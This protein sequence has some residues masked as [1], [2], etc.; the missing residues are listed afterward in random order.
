MLPSVDILLAAYNGE[1]Y[2]SQQIQSILNQTHKPQNIFINIDQS[3][4]K[5]VMIVQKYAKEFSEIHIINLNKRFGSSAANFFY[6]L[7]HVNFLNSDYVA[8]ADQDDIWN[9]D[10]LEKA[11]NKLKEGYD[12]YSSNVEA[13]WGNGEKKVLIKNQ[14]QKNYDHLF[15]SAG[16]G[17]TFVLK[18]NLALA[19]QKFLKQSQKDLIQMKN[20]HDWLIYTFARENNFH[21]FIDDYVSLKY[22]QHLLNDFGAHVGIRAS[23]SRA[24]RVIRGEGFDQ[25][26]LLIK[27]FN[28]QNNNFVRKWYPISRL[29]FIKLAFYA[30]HCRRCFREQFYFFFACILLAIIFPKKLCTI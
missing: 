4:D 7:M 30:P 5:T 19:L 17:C 26:I 3:S 2:I 11:I 9:E 8:L 23:I 6:L 29:G 13:I 27:L 14:P 16:P 18:N 1:K 22:R 21:W 12:G 28:L 10:K 20:Y 25:V 24:K 15:E